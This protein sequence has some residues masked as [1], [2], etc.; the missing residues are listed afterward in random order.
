MPE[1]T[2]SEQAHYEY[3]VEARVALGQDRERAERVA[4]AQVLRARLPM[5]TGIV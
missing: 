3:A 5:E 1:L 4:L 2:P